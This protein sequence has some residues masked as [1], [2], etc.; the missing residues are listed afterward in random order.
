MIRNLSRMT[1][2]GLLKSNLDANTKMV[3]EALSDTEKIHKARIHPL[4]ILVALRSYQLGQ[5]RHLTWQPVQGIVDAL[6]KAFYIAFK[7][8]EPTGQ[9]WLLAIDCSGSMEQPIGGYNYNSHKPQSPLDCRTAAAAM[10]LVTASVESNTEI[11]GFSDGHGFTVKGNDIRHADWGSGIA[12]I[13]ISPKSRLSDAVEVMSRFRWGGTDCALP[14]LYAIN[15]EIHVDTF[16]VY[17]DNETWAGKIHPTQA[18][19]K[20]RKEFNPNAKLIVVGMT[21]TE[22]SIADPNDSGMLDVAGF[23]TATPQIMSTFSKGEL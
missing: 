2:I 16:V 4:N 14:M 17:T 3:K 15:K 22:F 9:N 13:K 20:Y 18:L 7:N 1:S 5:G 19:A 10:S 21:A 11:V 12:P 6:D 23:D 8:V